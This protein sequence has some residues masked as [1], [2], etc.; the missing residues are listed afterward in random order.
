[1]AKLPTCPY[2]NK[3]V[4]KNEVSKKY[5]NRTY[6]LSCYQK[7]CEEIYKNKSTNNNSE[8]QNELYNYICQLFKIKELTPFLSFQLQK[9]FKENNFTYNG[10]LYSLKYFYEIKNNPV[11]INYGIGIVPVIYEEAKNFYIK[12]SIVWEKNSKINI[13]KTEK[14]VQIKSKKPKS[15]PMIDISKL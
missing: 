1:M 8:S 15:K 7:Y 10:V 2:C 14:T 12:K 4:Q 6:H 3:E 5:Q 11:D 13:N 9:I